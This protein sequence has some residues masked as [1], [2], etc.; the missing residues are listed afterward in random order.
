MP[1]PGT[2]ER[3][4]L[5]VPNALSALRLACVPVFV[6]LMLQ[7]HR[8]D[9]FAAAVLL[10]ALGATDWVDGFLARRLDQVS[11]LGK[12]LD[13]VADRLLLVTAAVSTVALG[14]VPV[15][16][17]TVAIA[18]EVVVAG[19]FL[20]VAAAGGRR[21]EVRRVGKLGAFGLMCALPLLLAGHSD[22][23]WHHL[24]DILGWVLAVPALVV[25]W[26]SVPG[27]A[28][29]ARRA[30]GEARVS[31]SRGGGSLATGSLAT[32][33]RAGEEPG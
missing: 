28:R 25:S 23:G 27:Y 10:G 31:A 24:A 13:P 16:V 17:A 32:G 12:V 5:T 9:W 33:A 1:D 22:I 29:G 2:A 11:T 8:R 15:L 20:Y 14:A 21:M 3:R 26:V 6:V 4:V 30:L 18:R 19:G 7:P